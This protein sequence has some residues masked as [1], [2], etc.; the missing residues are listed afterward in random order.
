MPVFSIFLFNLILL[1]VS[2][3]LSLNFVGEF[4]SLAG[5]FA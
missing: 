3:P 1:N 2:A 5:I 4:L